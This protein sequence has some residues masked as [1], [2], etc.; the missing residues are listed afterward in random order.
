MAKRLN[1]TRRDFMGGVALSLAAG[2]SLSPL[3]ILAMESKSRY[4]PPSLTGLRGN[5]IGSFE[6]A[7]AVSVGG[8]KFGRPKEQT[9]HTYDLVVVGGGIS[10]LAAAHFYRERAGEGKS[11]LVLDNHDDF[12]GHAKRN[13]FDVDG[14][15]LIGYGGSMTIESPG[16]YSKVSSQ[17]LKDLGIHTE[18][19]YDYFDQGYFS[20]RGSRPAIYF[21]ADKYG[22]NVTAPN[23]FANFRGAPD[24]AKQDETIASYPLSD[25]SRQALLRILNDKTDYLAGKGKE[26]KL[27]ILR[28]MSA[29]DYF[30][31]YVNMPEELVVIFRDHIKGYW[32]VGWDAISAFEGA[33]LEH[34]AIRNLGLDDVLWGADDIDEPFICHFP[35]GNASVARSLVRKLLPDAVPGKTMEDLVTSVIDY[36]MLDRRENGCRIRLN[37]TA[38]DVRHSADE[39]HVDVIYMRD[40]RPARVRGKHVVLAC[41]NAVIPDICSEVPAAQVEAISYAVK[42]PLVYTNIAV[43]NWKAWDELGTHSIYQ[44]Q[45]HYMHDFE[46]DFPVSMGDYR[47]TAGPDQP[48][49]IHGSVVPADPDKGLDQK[50]QSMAGRRQLY[51]MSFDDHEK[52]ILEQL[53]G[54]LSGGGFDVERDITAITVNRWPH[55][56]A[57]EYNSL[58]DPPEYDRNNGPHVAGRA[59]IGRISIAN[60]DSS[61]YAYVNGAVDAA[62][63]AVNEQ[64]AVG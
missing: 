62:D 56:Y 1:I 6:I 50:Q 35:D 45:A 11:I 38:V 63:R 47:F 36:S 43:R 46:L 33:R 24:R 2:T 54:A 22:R 48:A 39:K 55:G 37:S 42:V 61:A 14:E 64:I 41:Y 34:P 40:G 8:A 27:R 12:G 7:H 51:Q 26:E 10:G 57:Y 19:F 21:S 25:E 5:H 53:D 58:Y 31:E 20:R 32:G 30:R 23:V 13:E 44:P 4:Y 15:K 16:A 60:S 52:L 18:R 59:Q 9:D 28:S 29:S 3:E 17:L 49:V